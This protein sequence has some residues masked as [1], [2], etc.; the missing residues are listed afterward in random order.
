MRPIEW[1]MLILLSIFWGGSFFFVEIAL[2][3]IQ[4]FTIVFL[5]V[6]LAALIL[7]GVVYILGQRMP[8]SLKMWRAFFVM[9]ALN[10][11]IPFSLIVWGQTRIDSGVASILNATTPIFTVLLAHLMTTDEK[12][13]IRTLVGVLIGFL[14]VFIMMAP[15]IKDGFSWR[16]LGQIAVLGAAISYSFAGIF[17]KRLKNTSAVVNATGMLICSSIMMLPFA[18][19]IDSPW[20]L[21]PSLDAM[22]AVLGMATISTALAYLLY[23]G[24]LASAGATNVLLVTFLI[25]ISALLLGVGVLGEVIRSLEFTGMGCIFLWLV[26]IDGRVLNWIRKWLNIGAQIG[27]QPNIQKGK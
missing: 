4:P 20:T 8:A 3:D 11:A 27:Y 12:L 10:N 15:E 13:T 22:A 14:G 17:G 21:K 9:G 23:F 16:G 25:P 18:I 7:L 6:A 24:I 19:I 26:L 1:G 5:R 2:R